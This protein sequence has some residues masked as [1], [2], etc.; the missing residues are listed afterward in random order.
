VCERERAIERK[1]CVYTFMRKITDFILLS[2]IYTFIYILTFREKDNRMKERKITEWNILMTKRHMFVQY[3][4]FMCTTRRMHRVARD[5]DVTHA[6]VLRH[7]SFN[8]ALQGVA[9]RCSVLQCVAVRTT[10]LI[11]LCE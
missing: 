5:Y 10:R 11:H 7:D 4:P 3:D 1:Y 8:C 6:S 9:E 2:F